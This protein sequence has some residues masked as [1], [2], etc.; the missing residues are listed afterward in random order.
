MKR[1]F[2]ICQKTIPFFLRIGDLNDL[3]F[4]SPYFAISFTGLKMKLFSS[5]KIKSIFPEGL[6]EN[7]YRLNPMFIATFESV[8]NETQRSMRIN[9]N[10]FPQDNYKMLA[11]PEWV[12]DYINIYRS[13][14]DVLVSIN[15]DNFGGYGHYLLDILPALLQIHAVTK[16]KFLLVE[17]LQYAKLI[18]DSCNLVGIEIKKTYPDTDGFFRLN[19]S[20][21]ES[22]GINVTSSFSFYPGYIKTVLLVSRLPM[23][24]NDTKPFRKIYAVRSKSAASGRFIKNERPLIEWLKKNNFEIVRPETMSIQ[25]QFNLFS[26]A[27]LV[28]GASGSALLNVVFMNSNTTLLEITPSSD[29]RHGP[30]VIASILNINYFYFSG[31]CDLKC[32][33]IESKPNSYMVDI[34]LLC[35]KINEIQGLI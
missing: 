17:H 10:V 16:A 34:E 28:V 13:K 14:T 5:R 21:I 32:D 26:E 8:S 35:E 31:S 22:L 15:S 29:F 4:F 23:R 24:E 18:E 7:W 27:R 1:T 20:Q 2:G 6:W 19:S 11:I 25:K 30:S 3:W 9:G 33:Y 12:L